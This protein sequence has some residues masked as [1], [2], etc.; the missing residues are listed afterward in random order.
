M[1]DNARTTGNLRHVVVAAP[2]HL[3]GD[4]PHNVLVAQV[5]AGE[6]ARGEET[7]AVEDVVHLL[8]VHRERVGQLQHVLQLAALAEKVLEQEGRALAVRLPHSQVSRVRVGGAVRGG[9]DQ[10]VVEG[11]LAGCEC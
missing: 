1:E 11:H 8:P 9:G 5:E 7:H 2:G 4:T 6:R 3:Y 10:A